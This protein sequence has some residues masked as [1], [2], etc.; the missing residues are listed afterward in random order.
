MV[1]QSISAGACIGFRA[2]CFPRLGKCVLL[3]QI[4]VY[5][6]ENH[7]ANAD[8][9]SCLG[10]YGHSTDD[11]MTTT[12]TNIC[13]GPTASD[14]FTTSSTGSWA[15]TFDTTAPNGKREKCFVTLQA[16]TGLTKSWTI[17]GNT[18]TIQFD[19]MKVT[20]CKQ[21]SSTNYPHAW[22]PTD[23]GK[24][25]TKKHLSGCTITLN[26]LEPS[27]V[28]QSCAAAGMPPGL[29]MYPPMMI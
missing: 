19:Y 28:G 23:T 10:K 20:M 16:A 9:T 18:A 8:P 22:T 11:W 5:H 6:C 26:E 15:A 14:C 25:A 17:N 2:L 24:C 1:F 4:S 13:V 7:I 3:L 29:Q 27:F 12:A 21:Q